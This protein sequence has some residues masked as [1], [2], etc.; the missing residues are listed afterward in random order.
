MLLNVKPSVPKDLL[1]ADPCAD[2]FCK[3]PNDHRPW[4]VEFPVSGAVELVC[5]IRVS[6]WSFGL[7][8]FVGC[9]AKEGHGTNCANCGMLKGGVST[10]V[11]NFRLPGT[12]ARLP[13]I[14]HGTLGTP[15]HP[16]PAL[17]LST[18]QTV[19]RFHC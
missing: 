14:T 11:G 7:I 17:P 15:H 3:I 19:L 12:F 9:T 13:Y 5:R 1:T 16:P 6:M 18:Q 2:G 4:F 8:S 10:G